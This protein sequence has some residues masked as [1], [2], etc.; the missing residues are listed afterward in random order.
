MRQAIFRRNQEEGL[1]RILSTSG[2]PSTLDGGKHYIVEGQFKMPW[3]QYNFTSTPWAEIPETIHEVGSIYT[4]QGFDLNYT[5]I[6]I[7][8]IISQI[9]NTN[10]LQVNLDRVTDTEMFKRR[11]D[12][13]NPVEIEQSKRQM[14]M[15]ALNVILK[16]GVSGTYLYAHDPLLR[17]TLNQNYQTL[18][19][20]TR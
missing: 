18:L 8:P 9:S 14:I 13:T 10:Q 2:Y 19:R 15:N 16:R 6:I 20:R 11:D 7:G 3:D 1:S 17:T 4:C 12:L 5:G